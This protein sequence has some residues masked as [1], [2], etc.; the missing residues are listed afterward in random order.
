MTAAHQDEQL[1]LLASAR[2]PARPKP[3]EGLA[4]TDPVA[5]VIV[6]VGLAHLDRV[7]DYGVP[8]SMAESA[9]PGV[10]VRVRFAGR[11]VSGYLV[12]RRAEAD[13]EGRLTPLRRIVSDEVVLPPAL[14]AVCRDVARRWA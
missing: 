5:G 9:R 8:E 13:H 12:D 10:R 2:R 1:A 4:G 7:F 11:D 14:L 3:V 6:D